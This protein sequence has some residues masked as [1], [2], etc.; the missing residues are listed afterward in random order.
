MIKNKKHLHWLYS[1]TK[2]GAKVCYTRPLD[3]TTLTGK[4][5]PIHSSLLP[6]VADRL[7]GFT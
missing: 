7:A 4:Y 6:G 1:T 3:A 2:G 5:Q